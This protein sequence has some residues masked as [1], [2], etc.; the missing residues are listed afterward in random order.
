MKSHLFR[1]KEEAL[2]AAKELGCEGYH[3]TKR[4]SFKPCNSQDELNELEDYEVLE[5]N[6]TKYLFLQLDT[7]LF[8]EHLGLVPS[9]NRGN[10]DGP[11]IYGCLEKFMGKT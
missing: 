6:L 3:K 4:K 9:E 2:E 11:A 10:F 8:F 7:N 1:T 5:G